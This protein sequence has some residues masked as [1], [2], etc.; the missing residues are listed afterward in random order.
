[1]NIIFQSPETSFTSQ[2]FDNEEN[3]LNIMSPSTYYIVIYTLTRKHT[4]P[5]PYIYYTEGNTQ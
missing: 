2:N 1:M 4:I 5:V 3:H